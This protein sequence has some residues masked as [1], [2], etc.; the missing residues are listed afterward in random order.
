MTAQA[1]TNG[2]FVDALFKTEPA[3]TFLHGH[4]FRATPDLSEAMN[5][6]GA[7]YWH[8]DMADHESLTWSEKVYELFG[9][10]AGTP[11]ERDWAVGR[12]SE[13]SKNR[14]QQVRHFA[15]NRKFGFILDA[16]IKSE[17]TIHRWIRVMAVPILNDGRVVALH[18]LKRAL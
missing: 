17:G 15:L 5:D 10:P 16:S 4:I 8:C 9:V 18:G 7:G 11:V 6:P 2:S 14:L 13:K 1:P 3:G 12:Y